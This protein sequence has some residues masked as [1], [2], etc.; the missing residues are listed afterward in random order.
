MIF[1]IIKFL[2]NIIL[3][4]MLFDIPSFK[5]LGNSVVCSSLGVVKNTVKG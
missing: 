2:F 5:Y 4:L 3:Y 1:P